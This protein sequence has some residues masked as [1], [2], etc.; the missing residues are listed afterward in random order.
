MGTSDDEVEILDLGTAPKKLF[1][2]PSQPRKKMRGK[3]GATRTDGDDGDDGNDGWDYSAFETF[4]PYCLQDVNYIA[5]I[6]AL[7]E[8]RRRGRKEESLK[9]RRSRFVDSACSGICLL[10]TDSSRLFLMQG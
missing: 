3:K 5:G 10:F 7:E 8:A 2:T 9:G 6:L 1:T 4:H